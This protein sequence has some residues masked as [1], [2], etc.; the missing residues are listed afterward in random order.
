MYLNKIKTTIALQDSLNSKIA[1]KEWP[2]KG[3][4]FELAASQES[5]ELIDHIGWK[6]WKD[7]SKPVDMYQAK[8]ELVD[9]YHFI[10][11]HLIIASHLGKIDQEKI[12]KK[13]EKEFL[14]PVSNNEVVKKKVIRNILD[15]Q[16]YCI[17]LSLQR[18]NDQSND[19][20]IILFKKFNTVCRSMGM[21]FDE[22]FSIYV[23]KN[24]LNIF[25]QNNGYKEGTY[26]K[27]W[28]GLEDNVVLEEIMKKLEDKS[29]DEKYVDL[30]ML[31]LTE[32]YS[33]AKNN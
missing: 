24:C 1:G 7:L 11:S 29:S 26:V 3:L 15:F 4:C 17:N 6:F 20:A 27:T 21:T 8:L 33:K 10:L 23:G 22:L 31:E 2:L 16:K 19:A 5:G 14:N 28:N 12:I 13:I 25:R 9:I 30:I 18:H 32:K